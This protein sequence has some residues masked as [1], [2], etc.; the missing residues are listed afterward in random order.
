MVSCMCSPP[1]IIECTMAGLNRCRRLGEDWE[2]LKKVFTFLRPAAI[3]L[4]LRKLY[5]S[6]DRL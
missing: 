3:H 5:K 4:M 1:L 2:N 6:P